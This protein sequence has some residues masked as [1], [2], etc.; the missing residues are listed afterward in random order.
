MKLKHLGHPNIL[1][2]VDY[3]MDDEKPWYVAKYCEGGNVR[4]NEPYLNRQQRG[5]IISQVYQGLA[6]C[7]SKGFIRTNIHLRDIF[8]K[9]GIDQNDTS[10]PQPVIGDFERCN[11]IKN[12]DDMMEGLANIEKTV[13]KLCRDFCLIR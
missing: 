13:N 2:M 8:L 11:Q 9:T 6:Y 3:N 4:E 1:T 12:Y 10:E 5:A 7:L